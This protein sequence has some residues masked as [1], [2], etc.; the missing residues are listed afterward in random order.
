[1]LISLGGSTSVV[2]SSTTAHQLPASG[3]GTVGLGAFAGAEP[4]DDQVGLAGPVH[5]AVHE[6]DQR[7]PAA[8]RAG[9][10]PLDQEAAPIEGRGSA[11]P[12]LDGAP[13]GAKDSHPQRFVVADLGAARLIRHAGLRTVVVG[14]VRRGAGLGGVGEG[15]RRFGL[16]TLGPVAAS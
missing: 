1:M 5:H 7:V 12:V 15:G 6:T 13:A 14:I 16:L 4:P 9:P 11:F 3:I 2:A 8:G 10:R